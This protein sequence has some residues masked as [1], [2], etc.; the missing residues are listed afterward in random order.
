MVYHQVGL[1]EQVQISPEA[2]RLI[3]KALDYRKRTVGEVMVPLRHSV[4]LAPDVPVHVAVA[5]TGTNAIMS[6][7]KLLGELYELTAR[8]N[9]R[10]KDHPLFKGMNNPVKFNPQAV[11]DLAE[12]DDVRALA[13]RGAKGVGEAAAVL[14]DLALGKQ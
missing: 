11:A 10:A 9:A 1:S 7:Y 4:A 14:A 3:S 5:D 6:A 8:I 13:E 2:S 12:E